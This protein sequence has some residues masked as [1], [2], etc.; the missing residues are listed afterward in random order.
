MPEGVATAPFVLQGLLKYT[1][2]TPPFAEAATCSHDYVTSNSRSLIPQLDEQ[3]NSGTTWRMRST[4]IACRVHLTVSLD[5]DNALRP[6][7]NGN[8]PLHLFQMLETK[9]E[10][11]QFQWFEFRCGAS[12]CHAK[13]T[14]E[15][16]AP[17]L[18]N[19]DVD[20]MVHA[21]AL[22]KRAEQLSIRRGST[23]PASSA[24]EALSVLRSYVND[25][26]A[27][28]GTERK[29]FPDGNKRFSLALGMDAAVLL[30]RIGFEYEAPENGSPWGYWRLPSGGV[31]SDPE[32]HLTLENLSDELQAL[33]QRRP[34]TEK[35]P[36]KEPVSDASRSARDLER[37]LGS[38]DCKCHRL[39]CSRA[40]D[41]ISSCRSYE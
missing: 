10:T 17:V 34:D 9:V 19:V 2:Q 40:R 30:Q 4:C 39:S 20:M 5:F 1:P 7:P 11:P 29:K 37:M 15:I 13:L 38:F 33:M 28:S 21:A 25:A 35:L 31:G 18:N 16:R 6:C 26:L 12:E 3:A 22:K 27:Q 24:Y 32:L 14:T 8:F 23:V 36:V 41:Q